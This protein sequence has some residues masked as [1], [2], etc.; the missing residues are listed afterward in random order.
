MMYFLGFGVFDMIRK[1]KIE[2]SELGNIFIIED[3][4]NG[5]VY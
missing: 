2:R 1:S 3:V 4:Y 5:N